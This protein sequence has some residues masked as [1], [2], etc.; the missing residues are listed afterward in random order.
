MVLGATNRPSDLDEAI[1]R[2]LPQ[3]FE[4][5]KPDRGDREK[6]LKVILRDERVDDNIDF[7][8]IA[9]SLCDGYTGS[10]LLELSFASKQPIFLEGFLTG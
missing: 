6:I 5:G 3:V 2:R 10:Y 8:H 7:N 4:I 9:T 1:L